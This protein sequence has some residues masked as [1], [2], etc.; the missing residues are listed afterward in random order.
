MTLPAWT[1]GFDAWPLCRSVAHFARTFSGQTH[2]PD[3]EQLNQLAETLKLH[4][5]AGRALGFSA[6]TQACGQRHYEAQIF[7]TGRVPT[8][9][10][11]WHDFF[12]AL[13][14]FSFPRSKAALNAVQCAEL[15]PAQAGRRSPRSDAATLFDE[16]GLVLVAA[17]PTL[18]ELLR[19]KQW[20]TAFWEQ[21]GLWDKA[22]LHVI[23]HALM[24]R[25]ATPYPGMTGK[26]LY[27]QSDRL[28]ETSTPPDWLDTAIAH[29][30]QTGQ[31]T[32]PADLITI[33]VQGVPGFDPDN[34]RSEYY[35]DTRVFRPPR[36]GVNPGQGNAA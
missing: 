17:E 10:D 28:P 4:N 30:W 5:A 27:I 36:S 8:R 14:W 26:C 2:W 25:A 18:A 9:I 32:R 35:D 34:A 12:N 6:Q 29:A 24:E 33:P 31:I 15:T 3:T 16:S 22:H 21:R 13:A 19:T 1:P 11:S 23:G 20:K 7:E